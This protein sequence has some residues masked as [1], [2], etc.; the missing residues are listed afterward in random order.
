MDTSSKV[1]IQK[2]NEMNNENLSK[3]ELILLTLR[4][5][6]ETTKILGDKLTQLA[7][8]QNKIIEALETLNFTI[9]YKK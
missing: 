8:N 3:D 5:S 2:V 6:L 4:E 7:E 9:V 1:N